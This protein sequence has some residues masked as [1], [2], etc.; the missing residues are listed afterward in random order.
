VESA[1]AEALDGVSDRD[2]TAAIR[3]LTR[4]AEHLEP[5]ASRE[6]EPHAIRRR[7]RVGQ[8]PGEYPHA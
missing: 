5:S 8:K 4:L 3:V 2:R 6:R 1:I 7:P